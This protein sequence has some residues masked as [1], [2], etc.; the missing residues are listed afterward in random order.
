MGQGCPPFYGKSTFYEKKKQRALAK[1]EKLREVIAEC[2][3]AI[4]QA[5]KNETSAKN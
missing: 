5:A 4:A 3:K 2:D 1:I